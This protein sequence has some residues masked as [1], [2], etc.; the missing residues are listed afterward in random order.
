M[1][2]TKRQKQKALTRKHL[3]EIAIKQFGENGII[4]TRTSDISKAANVSH[5]TLF[6]HFSTQEE[7][8]IAVIEEFGTRITQR[9]H[10]LVD[11]NSS[12]YEVLEAHIKGLIE[13]EPF[14]TRLIIE[15]RLLPASA[16]NTYIIIQSNISFHIGKAAEKEIDKSV[17]RKIPIHLIFNTW[18]SLVHYY[19]TN[20]DLFSS[21]GSILKQY[22]D[23]LLHHYISLITL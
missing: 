5:G 21:N 23:E 2:E 15:R 4:A 18:I 17:I 7:L 16:S 19:L 6:A 8:L 22:G 11:T 12:L 14:Y 10:E 13:F 3:T 1:S 20:G 9:L